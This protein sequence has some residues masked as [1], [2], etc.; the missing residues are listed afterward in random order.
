MHT[1]RERYTFIHVFKAGVLLGAGGALL[2][3]EE[4]QIS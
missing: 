4:G 3:A 2:E 1:Y